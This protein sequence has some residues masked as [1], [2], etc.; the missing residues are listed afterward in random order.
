MILVQAR[1]QT[2]N[3]M[4][5]E[6]GKQEATWS[7]ERPPQF[8]RTCGSLRAGE[9]HR[10]ADDD[11]VKAERSVAAALRRVSAARCCS[12]LTMPVINTQ[13]RRAA[14]SSDRTFNLI[15]SSS[16]IITAMAG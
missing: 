1:E 14:N 8:W 6:G 5:S 16:A 15:S 2:A 4:T 7:A 3:R 9:G 11:D 12:R 10:G 13:S